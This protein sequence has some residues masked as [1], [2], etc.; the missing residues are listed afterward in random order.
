MVEEERVVQEKV[1]TG[2]SLQRVS[3]KKGDLRDLF[4]EV[5]G[6]KEKAHGRNCLSSKREVLQKRRDQEGVS[7]IGAGLCLSLQ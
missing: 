4:E 5:V 7:E 6:K 3:R 2:I 1:R